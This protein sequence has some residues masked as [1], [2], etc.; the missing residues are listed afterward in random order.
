MREEVIGKERERKGGKGEVIGRE[1][2]EEK[3]KRKEGKEDVIGRKGRK[4][5]TR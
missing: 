5:W 3:G 4:E 2:K 1:G